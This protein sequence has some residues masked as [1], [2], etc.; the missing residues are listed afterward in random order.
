MS[1]IPGGNQQGQRAQAQIPVDSLPQFECKCGSTVFVPCMELRFASRLVSQNGQPTVVQ[2][3]GGWA[4]LACGRQNKF[5]RKPEY[6]EIL[7]PEEDDE[8]EVLE[9]LRELDE[10]L[11][12]EKEI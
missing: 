1:A 5:A 10:A 6:A 11:E 2:V 12:G 4:C 8:D 7:P 3:P 9:A